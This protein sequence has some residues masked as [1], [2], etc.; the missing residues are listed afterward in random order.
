MERYSLKRK[1]NRRGSIDLKKWVLSFL[2]FI[3][4]LKTS[5]KVFNNFCKDEKHIIRYNAQDKLVPFE[6]ILFLKGNRH[7][8]CSNVWPQLPPHVDI[9][10]WN[11]NKKVKKMYGFFDSYEKKQQA[12]NQCQAYIK[13]IKFDMNQLQRVL[14]E[15]IR[16]RTQIADIIDV[17]DSNGHS[18][19]YATNKYHIQNETNVYNNIT[20]LRELFSILLNNHTVLQGFLKDL[21]QTSSNTFF[22][23]EYSE[24]TISNL[25]SY[26]DLV[27][28]NS[29][30]E[31]K[32]FLDILESLF[33]Q[34]NEQYNALLKEIMK[35][36]QHNKFNNNIHKSYFKTVLD[37]IIIMQK[38]SA[39]RLQTLK[40]M[41]EL[42]L[43]N[44]NQRKSVVVSLQDHLLSMWSKLVGTNYTRANL[45]FIESVI[46]NGNI[47][48]S[49]TM[50]DSKIK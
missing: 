23:N 30:P 22:Q 32:K 1:T 3:L 29:T 5:A 35:L 39:D 12:L 15:S 41:G 7:V 14:H 10:V 44:Q 2:L 8:A 47:S 27:N 16:L 49:I 6:I 24:I 34:N 20:Q 4:C 19:R 50:W 43:R 31:F 33:S 18:L 25:R 42:E 40:N 36:L 9:F 28:K 46:P 21:Q 38:N 11:C 13:Q 26:I 17:G 37:L 45:P 48:F